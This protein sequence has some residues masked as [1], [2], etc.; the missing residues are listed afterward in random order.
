METKIQASPAVHCRPAEEGHDQLTVADEQR[1][2][3]RHTAGVGSMG[4]KE[5]EGIVILP[6]NDVQGTPHYFIVERAQSD[7]AGLSITYIGREKG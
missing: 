7:P 4:R 5:T 3:H 6:V 2:E 1:E